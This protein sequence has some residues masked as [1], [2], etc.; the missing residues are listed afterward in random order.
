MHH[1]W[2]VKY[3][4]P[5][6]AFIHGRQMSQL[7]ICDD[8]FGCPCL[9]VSGASCASTPWNWRPARSNKRLGPHFIATRRNETVCWVLRWSNHCP[10]TA[11]HVVRVGPPEADTPSRRKKNQH[12]FCGWKI[13][14]SSQVDFL[15]LRPSLKFFV[16]RY[17]SERQWRPSR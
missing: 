15:L 14:S 1:R 2:P 17:C 4:R 6:Q 8:G 13:F 9:G 10:V 16:G 12:D 11:C 5:S 7:I 3:F